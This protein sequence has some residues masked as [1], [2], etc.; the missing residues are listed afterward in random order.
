MQS[1]EIGRIMRNASITIQLIGNCYVADVPGQV[2]MISSQALNITYAYSLLNTT[3]LHS[4]ANLAS[5][6]CS[7]CGLSKDHD[8]MRLHNNSYIKD[9]IFK[10]KE[11]YLQLRNRGFIQVKASSEIRLCSSPKPPI[12]VTKSALTISQQPNP[13]IESKTPL[14]RTSPPYHTGVMTKFSQY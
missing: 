11:Q 2:C 8:A 12:S 9:H 6:A 13:R 10:A 1:A 14:T 4:I 5:T 7:P 3:V